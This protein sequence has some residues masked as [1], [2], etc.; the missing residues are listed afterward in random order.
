MTQRLRPP[1]PG[2]SRRALKDLAVPAEAVARGA[3]RPRSV[4]LSVKSC[5]QHDLACGVV[6]CETGRDKSVFRVGGE[7]TKSQ[8][9]LH[10][11]LGCAGGAAAAASGAARVTAEAAAEIRPG[12]RRPFTHVSARF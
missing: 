11:I 10:F 1:S 7:E 9:K 6:D 4:C 2:R 3:Q 8:L 5:S 12:P